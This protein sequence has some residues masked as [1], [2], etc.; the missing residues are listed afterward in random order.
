MYG[1]NLFNFTPLEI[2]SVACVGYRVAALVFAWCLFVLA[3]RGI[4]KDLAAH[5][6]AATL[7]FAF[8]RTCSLFHRFN[9]VCNIEALFTSTT[10]RSW[11]E[12]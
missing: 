2:N 4:L 3:S 1:A 11:L 7:S 9:V 10:R 8:A 6:N 5:N 12:T